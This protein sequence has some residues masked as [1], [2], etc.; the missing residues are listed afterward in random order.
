MLQPP[1]AA[2]TACATVLLPEVLPD[3]VREQ[4]TRNAREGLV[5][6]YLYDP[7]VATATARRLRASLPNWVTLLYAVKANSFS[8]V[9]RA[10]LADGGADGL[11]VASADELRLAR[12]VLPVG[13]VVAAGPGKTP[14]LLTA[15]IA[16]DVDVIHA[17]SVLELHRI[18]A[19]AQEYAVRP[20]VALRINPAR[21]AVSGTLGMGGRGSAFGI[22]EPDVPEAIAIAQRLPGIDLAGFHVHAVSGNRDAAAHAEYIRWCLDWSVRTAAAHGVELSWLD[23][24]GG[25]GVTYDGQD[26]L[27]LGVLSTELDRIVPPAGLQLAIEPGRWLAAGCGWYA[28]EVIDIKR[29]Y[30]ETFVVVRGGINAFALPGTESFPFPMVV[31]PIDDRRERGPRPEALSG[32]VTVAG[33]LC[34]PED[35]LVRD[36]HVDRIR[37]G[38]LVVLPNAGAYGWEFA[39]HSFLGHPIPTRQTVPANSPTIPLELEATA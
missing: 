25:L 11:E 24:G 31:L 12:D 13:P 29:S 1:S 18:N 34:T 22:P 38:D 2:G 15:L 20:R 19:L 32:P 10:L 5:G 33:E 37:V 27:D 35:V 8:P 28:A 4:L 23:V 6:G 26:A 16:G 36:V 30:G 39:L 7:D 3:R 14:E 9:V 21:I 17:E